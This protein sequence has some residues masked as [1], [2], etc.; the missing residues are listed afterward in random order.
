[1]RIKLATTCIETARLY[2]SNFIHERNK[3][4]E[5]SPN[6]LRGTISIKK[7]AGPK[8]L[9]H[10]WLIINNTPKWKIFSPED[11]YSIKCSRTQLIAAGVSAI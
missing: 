5:R 9:V 4:S 8:G 1:M 10:V 2:Q 11:G 7:A 3:I 6:R